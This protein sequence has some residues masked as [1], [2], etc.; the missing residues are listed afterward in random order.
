MEMN[1]L[2]YLDRVLAKGEKA[3]STRRI[4]LLQPHPSFAINNQSRQQELKFV[5]GSR[6]RIQDEFN[7]T[8]QQIEL[9]ADKYIPVIKLDVRRKTVVGK[10]QGNEILLT[11]DRS[12]EYRG[13]SSFVSSGNTLADHGNVSFG[14][15]PLSHFVTF[16]CNT[17]ESGWYQSGSAGSAH[18]C[19]ELEK[20]PFLI[21][22]IL[23]DIAMFHSWE[24]LRERFGNEPGLGQEFSAKKVALAQ[25]LG[26]E[27]FYGPLQGDV[28]YVSFASLIRRG[29]RFSK[30]DC[31]AY[32]GLWKQAVEEVSLEAPVREP[33]EIV[34]ALIA[35]ATRGGQISRRKLLSRIEALGPGRYV[36]VLAA[37]RPRRKKQITQ[38]NNLL[39]RS[40]W[41][42]NSWVVLPY[43]ELEKVLR[44]ESF[45]HFV[46]FVV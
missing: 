23:L 38:V 31:E 32:E 45:L 21:A 40:R 16:S 10:V 8:R 4:L 30:D 29:P 25:R 2:E 9:I 26:L 43:E 35:K 39:R 5:Y 1:S 17:S 3:H 13:Y 33:E 37:R 27:S 19:L 44:F 6:R 14:D 28:G 36:L 22:D 41:R 20:V 12:G 7:R 24:S 34:D 18:V 46:R 15:V 11:L 42:M